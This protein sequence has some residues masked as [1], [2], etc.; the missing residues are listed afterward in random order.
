VS[1]RFEVKLD[2][3]SYSPG[4]T[5]K[6][7]VLVTEGGA[8]RGLEAVLEYKEEVED[9]LE[10]AASISSGALHSGDLT[11]GSSFEFELTLPGDALP[12]YRSEHGELYWELDVLSDEAGV[13]THERRRVVVRTLE[14]GLDDAPGV[15]EPA[16][17]D[18]EPTPMPADQS[19]RRSL[20]TGKRLGS[21]PWRSEGSGLTR[22]IAPLFFAVGVVALLVGLVTL[23]FTVRFIQRAE[24]ATGTVIELSRETDSDGEVTFYPVVRFETAEGREI[25]FKS[26]SGSSPPS[27]SEG[28]RVD[29]LY[30]PDDPH[31]ARLSGFFDLWLF[32]IVGFALGVVFIV[33]SLFVRRQSSSDD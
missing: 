26:S 12:N 27:H 11:T 4:E 19:P 10:V 23:V 9:Y 13:D 16:P 5:V 31:D 33:V 15:F 6:G 17:P 24:H 32:P 22:W 14:G 7:S 28:D 20:M 21:M 29:V 30:D 2:Q 18:A 8:S 1:P 3:E 25:E